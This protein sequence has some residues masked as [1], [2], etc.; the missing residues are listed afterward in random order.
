MNRIKQLREA[1]GLSMKDTADALGIPYTTYINYEKGYRE[2]NSEMLIKLSVF[3]E[4]S[5]D[6]LI[7]KDQV[8]ENGPVPAERILHKS[9]IALIQKYRRLPEDGK[10]A[11]EATINALLAAQ[12]IQFEENVVRMPVSALETV[13]LTVAAEGGQGVEDRV[14][15]KQDADEAARIVSQALQKQEA[16]DRELEE[17]EARARAYFSA[18]SDKKKKKNPFTKNR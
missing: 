1:K 2:P 17:G 8:T 6:Y 4:T 16:E 3:F 5:I 10:L 13:P 14:V 11:V 7:G 12:P 9:E 18:K 15:R